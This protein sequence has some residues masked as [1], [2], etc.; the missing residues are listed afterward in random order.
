[1]LRGG[2]LPA[3]T[4][5]PF[6][7]RFAILLAVAGYGIGSAI[8]MLVKARRASRRGERY[9]FAS[10]DGGGLLKGRSVAPRRAM[11]VTTPMVVI[12]AVVVWGL[13][14]RRWPRPDLVFEIPSGWLDVSSDRPAS[15]YERL[16]AAF[17]DPVRAAAQG[18]KRYA[19]DLEHLDERQGTFPSFS[20]GYVH[21]DGEVSEATMRTLVR[22]SLGDV[23]IDPPQ[24]E[25]IELRSV[26]GVR[27][28]HA[29]VD[30][31]HVGLRMHF[32]AFARGT[33]VVVMACT[34][35]FYVAAQVEP[36]CD[37]TAESTAR[38]NS[39]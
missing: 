4:E 7:I 20:A 30:A 35:P 24:R 37:A 25:T 32:Y 17:R 2:V 31:E 39:R 21:G 6:E 38:R 33:T 23:G 27:M 3:M 16:P 18:V 14:T 13:V 11:L 26:D 34:V 8:A 1:M 29:V 10:W 5:L 9:V 36:L 28:G 19:V 15:S 12:A 22:R